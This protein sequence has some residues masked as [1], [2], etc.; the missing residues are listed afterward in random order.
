MRKM[1]Q[2][3]KGDHVQ[4]DGAPEPMVASRDEYDSRVWSIERDYRVPQS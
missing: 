3:R 1:E 2:I 4:V